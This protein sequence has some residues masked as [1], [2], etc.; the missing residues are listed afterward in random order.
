[1]GVTV[2][3]LDADD[4]LPIVLERLDRIRGYRSRR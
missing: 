2:L 1:V 4:P 3:R